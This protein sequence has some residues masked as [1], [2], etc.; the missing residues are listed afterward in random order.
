MQVLTGLDI[1]RQV[2]NENI[3]EIQK[4]ILINRLNEHIEKSKK[5]L[6][7]ISLETNIDLERLERILSNEKSCEENIYDSITFFELY[8]ITIFLE[9]SITGLIYEFDQGCKKVIKFLTA[10]KFTRNEIVDIFEKYQQQK[11]M[12]MLLEWN[13]LLEQCDNHIKTIR[14]LHS[15]LKMEKTVKKPRKSGRPKKTMAAKK[16]GP[17]KKRRSNK[18]VKST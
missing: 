14:E 8:K 18:T 17:S 2:D 5:S 3:A 13:D 9:R 4:I 12:N 10:H 11:F 16:D 1:D 15:K 6:E 7:D